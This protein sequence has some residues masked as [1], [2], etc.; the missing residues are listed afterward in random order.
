MLPRDRVLE[1]KRVSVQRLAAQVFQ[2]RREF[3]LGCLTY[4]R[5]NRALRTAIYRV[6]NHRMSHAAAFR[7]PFHSARRALP[8]FDTAG[9]G[10]IG[11]VGPLTV[12]LGSGAAGAMGQEKIIKLTVIITWE[13]RNRPIRKD[14]VTYITE[15]GIFR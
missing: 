12:T 9:S 3:S 4:L 14:I 10:A 1:R 15:N 5:R 7:S 6:A 2:Q 13:F 8:C 11:A